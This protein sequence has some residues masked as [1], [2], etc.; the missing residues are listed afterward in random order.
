MGH[1]LPELNLF[2]FDKKS[3][4]KFM[5][6]NVW[7]S[8]LKDWAV[9]LFFSG[10]FLRVLNLVGLVGFNPLISLYQKQLVLLLRF[11]YHHP[12]DLMSPLNYQMHHPNGMYVSNWRV[13]VS[14]L[15]S[16]IQHIYLLFFATGHKNNYLENKN[17]KKVRARSPIYQR[18]SL[19]VQSNPEPLE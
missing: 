1:V 8:Y 13:W 3:D 4:N 2:S 15:S 10:C 19:Q 16:S 17:H 18:T 14:L 5:Q 6:F 9:S 12:L 7:G 11:S